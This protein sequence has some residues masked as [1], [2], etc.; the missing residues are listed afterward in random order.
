MMAGSMLPVRV[1]FYGHVRDVVS[2]PAMETQVND[3]AT[4]GALL[5]TLV[6]R[7]GEPLRQRLL[8][9]QGELETNVQIFVGDDQVRSL[10]EPLVGEGEGGRGKGEGTAIPGEVKV[11]VLSACAGG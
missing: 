7:F 2:E 9:S 6:E 11:F 8:T 10:R 4:V 5:D 3:Q 1:H